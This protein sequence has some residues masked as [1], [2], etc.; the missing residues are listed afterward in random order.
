MIPASAS[1]KTRRHWLP[2]HP[3]ARLL[4]VNGFAGAGLGILFVLAILAFDIAGIR[5]LL[6]NGGE[7]IIG[8]ALLTVGSVTTFASVAMG[9]AIMLVRNPSDLGLRGPGGG[10]VVPVSVPVRV[11]AK[12][13]P[14]A[15]PRL[16]TD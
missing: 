3:L 8:L 10:R 2:R 13:R 12:R 11:R 5:T 14:S 1:P 4:V 9:G 15:T 6:A 7:W 16:W